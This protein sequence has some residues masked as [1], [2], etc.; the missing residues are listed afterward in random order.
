MPGRI[1]YAF[2]YST[3]IWRR[4]LDGFSKVDGLPSSSYMKSALRKIIKRNGKKCFALWFTS[5]ISNNARIL[6]W[7][8]LLGRKI[9]EERTTAMILLFRT[10]LYHGY[11]SLLLQNKL[12]RGTPI[13]IPDGQ[14]RRSKWNVGRGWSKGGSRCFSNGEEECIPGWPDR[15]ENR[16][17]LP[18]SIT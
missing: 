10:S 5:G 13:I 14:F 1:K 6:F 7:N 2:Y 16:V 15:K 11:P 8:W 3:V 9:L 17:P 4:S 12:G 18:L